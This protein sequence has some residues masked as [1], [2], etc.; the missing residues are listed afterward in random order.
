MAFTTGTRETVAKHSSWLCAKVRMATASTISESTS[1]VSCTGS[2]RPS[3]ESLEP[4]SRAWPPSWCIPTSKATRV[5]VEL[6]S[7][8]SASVRP[9]SGS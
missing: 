3:C 9:R 6:S 7:K 8:I 1:A 5:R 4:M 2:P